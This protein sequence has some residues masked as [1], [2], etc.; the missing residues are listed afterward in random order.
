MK[1]FI[2]FHGTSN[3]GVQTREKALHWASDMLNTTKAGKIYLTEITDTIERAN[4]PIEVKPFVAAEEEPTVSVR[5]KA[6]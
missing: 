5:A 2:A 1:K 6:A 3:S 4:V